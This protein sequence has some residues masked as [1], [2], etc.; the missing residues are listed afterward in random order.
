MDALVYFTVWM[1]VAGVLFII[2]LCL[3]SKR[4]PKQ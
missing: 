4:I 2:G 1:Q 3:I